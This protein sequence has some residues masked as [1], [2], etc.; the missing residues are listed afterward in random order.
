MGFLKFRMNR[1]TYWACLAMVV[2]WALFAALILEKKSGY[3]SEVIIACICVGRI[4]DVG[5]SGWIVGGILVAYVI[6]ALLLVFNL[7]EDTAFVTLGVINIVITGLLIL[8]GV[9]RGENGAN[10]YGEQPDFGINFRLSR[11]ST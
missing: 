5:K 3:V 4:H 8:L 10:R 7:D 9:L 6:G 1:A 11:S 2:A